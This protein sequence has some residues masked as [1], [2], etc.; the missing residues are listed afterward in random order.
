MLLRVEEGQRQ[1]ESVLAGALALMVLILV[2][3][4]D[5]ERHNR[6]TLT[7]VREVT[8]PQRDVD[9]WIGG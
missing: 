6:R 5:R 7:Y 9:R 4:L 3:L 8:Q 2:V 1:T